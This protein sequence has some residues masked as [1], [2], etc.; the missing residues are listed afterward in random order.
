[1]SVRFNS[2]MIV[3]IRRSVVG[4]VNAAQCTAEG[5]IWVILGFSEVILADTGTLVSIGSGS[6]WKWN[7]V[8][9]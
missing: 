6:T 5:S 2:I 7:V 3:P 1:M 8:G 9:C 4:K